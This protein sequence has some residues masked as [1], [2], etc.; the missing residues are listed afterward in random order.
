MLQ[1]VSSK[2]PPLMKLLRENNCFPSLAHAATDINADIDNSTSKNLS[3]GE[4]GDYFSDGSHPKAE[5]MDIVVE[6]VEDQLELFLGR[7]GLDVLEKNKTVAS[8]LQDVTDCDGSKIEGDGDNAFRRAIDEIDGT[9]RTM[10]RSTATATSTPASTF[11]SVLTPNSSVSP[12]ENVS[13]EK[14]D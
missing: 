10:V 14:N 9:L 7:Y 6:K 5:E 2:M 8:I 11:A 13:L 1:E 3:S 4:H 12:D